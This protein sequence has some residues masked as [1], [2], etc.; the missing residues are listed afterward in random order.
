MFAR[1]LSI[2][3]DLPMK[4]PVCMAPRRSRKGIAVVEFAVCLPILLI[5]VFGSVEACNAIYLKQAATASAYE[6]VR[7]ATG[8]GGTKIAGQT[9]GEEILSA[10]GISNASL[11]F[12]P[13]DES[14]WNRGV[15]ISALVSVP[16]SNNLGGINL[17]FQGKQLQSTIVMI[18][19]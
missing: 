8:S 7:V 11:T 5:V 17:F 2:T 1:L 6:A 9:R 3:N 12:S 14:S 19:Q 4:L 13:V 16:A 10:R 15:A 18:K